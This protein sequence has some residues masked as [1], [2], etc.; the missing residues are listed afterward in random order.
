MFPDEDT[1]PTDAADRDEDTDDV[2]MDVIEEG[3][4]MTLWRGAS[5]CKD[6]KCAFLCWVPWLYGDKPTSSSML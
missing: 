2:W 6:L 4:R 5:D 3:S 1:A